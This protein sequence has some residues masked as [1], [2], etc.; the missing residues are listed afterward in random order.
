MRS[1]TSP[2]PGAGPSGLAPAL[3]AIALGIGGCSSGSAPAFDLTAPGSVRA[4]GLRAG[5][6]V[7]GEPT[8]IQPLEAERIL[9][10]DAAGSVSYISDAQWADR[11]PRLFQT[12][13]IQ[14]FENN[15]SLKAV[16]RPGEGVTAV[17]QLNSELR[18]FQLDSATR[19]AVV[20]VSVKIL[21]VPTGK[22]VN[23]RIFKVRTP[24]PAVDGPTVAQALDRSL[25]GVLIDIVRWAGRL[26]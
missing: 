25:S 18:A 8:A 12:R 24:V 22:V 7:I 14:T 3:L 11:L 16:G 4:G 6:L 13:L 19:E 23:A 1:P 15:S 2:R 9:A 10:R 21:N 20:E 5:Q 26:A 17:F